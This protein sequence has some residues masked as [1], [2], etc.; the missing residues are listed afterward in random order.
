MAQ[1]LSV[2]SAHWLLLTLAMCV[3][4]C[5][6]Q[7]ATLEIG[8]AVVPPPPPSETEVERAIEQC[9]TEKRLGADTEFFF[10]VPFQDQE[11]VVRWLK[12]TS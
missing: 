1:L 9:V 11:G 4:P 8:M 10:T 12:F 5:S 6:L 7:N 3:H 2:A